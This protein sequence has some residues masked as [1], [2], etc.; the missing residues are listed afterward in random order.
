MRTGRLNRYTICQAKQGYRH[1][2]I[3]TLLLVD[4]RQTVFGL[5]TWCG[6]ERRTRSQ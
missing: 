3:E 5:S 4:N 6:C 2:T 1:E